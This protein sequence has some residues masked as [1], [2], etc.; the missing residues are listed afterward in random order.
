MIQDVESRILDL[1]AEKLGVRPTSAD[2]LAHLNLDSLALAEFS[3]DLEKS[4]DVRLD[5]HVLDLN[6]V[7]DMVT[8]VS[9]L[10]ERA[11]T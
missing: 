7:G 1:L 4:F 10:C 5:E 6:T 8:Y 2:K 9:R 3:A 11:R